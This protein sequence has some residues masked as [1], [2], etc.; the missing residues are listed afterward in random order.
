MREER[1]ILID[2]GCDKNFRK[3]EIT[4]TDR[5]ELREKIVR[6]DGQ[7]EILAVKG[8]DENWRKR[9]ITERDDGGD[10]KTSGVRR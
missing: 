5:R 9:A 10:Y 2:R 3:K 8:E 4:R 6:T 1:Q 7:D